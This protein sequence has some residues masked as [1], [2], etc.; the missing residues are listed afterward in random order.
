MLAPARPG[1]V[2]PFAGYVAKCTQGFYAQQASRLIGATMAGIGPG[3][4]DIQLD[5][6][7]QLTQQAGYLHGGVISM[8][9]DSAS[10][11]AAL[12]MMDEHAGVVSVEFKMNFLAPAVATRYVARGRV[13]KPG[14]SL[15]VTQCEVFGLQ[16]GTESMVA[17]MQQTLFVVVPKR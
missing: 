2:P 9:A 5:H 11:F 6:H 17:L 10:G 8:I 7:A 15:H 16:D 4:C 12:S 3:S 1:F 14:R 13:V